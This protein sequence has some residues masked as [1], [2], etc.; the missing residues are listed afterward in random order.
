MMARLRAP[1][2]LVL[3]VALGAVGWLLLNT[4]FL[5]HDDEGYVL[6]S[7][8][9][10][11]EHG[12][13]Y[14][15]IFTQYGPVPFIYH[16]LVHR[17]LGLPIT[18]LLGRSLTLLHWIGA[19]T[20]AALIAWRL[21]GRYWTALVTLVLVF[22]H[23][24]QNTW[25]PSHPGSLISFLAAVGLA[26]VVEL[27]ARGKTTAAFGVFGITG[28]A[29]L[30]TKINIGVFWCCA[31]GAFL[32][33]QTEALQRNRAGAWLAGLG[34]VLLPF[35]LMHNLLDEARTL[36]FAAATAVI[37]AGVCAIIAAEATPTLRWRHWLA[38]AGALAGAAALLI[39]VTLA[40]GTSV[41]GLLTGVVLD[42]LRHPAHFHFSFPWHPLGWVTIT[43]GGLLTV[44]W[45]IRPAW[46]AVLADITAGLR[47]LA[48][49]CLAWQTDNWIHPYGVALLISYLLPLAPIFLLPLGPVPAGDSRRLA[50]GCVALV[51]ILQVL[52][53]FPVAGSQMSWGTFLLLPLFVN[54][55]AD[56]AHHWARRAA[57]P[58][59]E[60][61]VAGIALAT[62][63]W[64]GTLLAQRGWQQWQNTVPLNLAG[65]ESIR[66]P[67][68]IRYAMRIITANAQIHADVLF[69][70]PGMYGFN[71]WS[72][73]PT[74]TERN[75]T[76][77]FWLLDAGE[78]T[79]I[80]AR[81]ESVK[82]SAVINSQPLVE[83]LVR[84]LHMQMTGPLND[85]IDRHYRRLFTV[86]GYDFLVPAE[87]QAAAF[88]VAQNFSQKSGLSGSE[89]SLI[90]VKVAV[91][92]DITRIALRDV[93]NP[94]YN[95]GE[96]HA[97]NA[98]ATLTKINSAGQPGG[99]PEAAPWPLHIDGLRELRLYHDQPLP[100]DRADLELVFFDAT[101]RLVFEAC[102]QDPLTVS[103][104]PAG[105]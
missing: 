60:T 99:S 67:E 12:G 61:V 30:L 2:L 47:I 93:R 19:A 100:R 59:L 48:L 88:F 18:N 42:P 29:L 70:R 31:G 6:I 82:R 102:Y 34:L 84:D 14:D 17:L 25:E 27:I 50:A 38:C 52:H 90:A 63:G 103:S 68:N 9:N 86:T 74:P 62:V 64:Q 97:G 92:A 16:D 33:L 43:G 73:V 94:R 24:R 66:P 72:G 65:A 55:L 104:P 28:A 79:A 36:T 101:G 23:L 71:L 58:W 87:S 54:G 78:Q 1:G 96:W 11:A 5:V 51:A 105:D 95:L 89:P 75:A 4:S 21:S 13:L 91:Q 69:S 57:R 39:G 80:A 85:F 41:H 15:V 44:L 35:G 76:H 32:L 20:A 22:G 45:C 7:L 3:A 8:R 37:G 40:R 26:V 10:Y 49:A 53:A 56:A 77:W 83:L 81:L 98:R 46:R